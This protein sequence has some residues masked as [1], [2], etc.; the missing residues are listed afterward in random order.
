MSSLFKS[1]TVRFPNAMDVVQQKKRTVPRNF[2]AVFGIAVLIALAAWALSALSHQQSLSVVDKS[3]L[4]LD[5]AQRGT[6]VQSVSAQG[7]F[8]PERLRIVS[9]TQPGIVDQI[10]VKA[11]SAVSTGDVI[12]QMRNP[13]LEAAVVGAQSSLQVAQANLADARQ[14]AQAAIITEQSNLADA[15]AQLQSNTLQ[16]RSYASLHRLGMVASLPYQEAKI[17]AEK[18]ANA[19]R[20]GR[21]QVT[22]AVA[23]AQAKVAAA[24]AQVDQ[25]HAELSAAQAQVAALTVRAA[26]SGIVQAVD[27]DPGASITPTTQIAS[28]ADVHELKAVLQVAETDVHSVTIGMPAQIDTGNGVV[29]GRV[30]HIAPTAENGSVAVDVIFARPISGARPDANVNGTIV[31]STIRNAVSIARPAGASDGSA[32]DLFKIEKGGTRAVR[33]QVRLGRGSS[34]RVQVLSGISAGDT[35]IVSDMSNYASKNEL[36]LR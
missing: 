1:K 10:L 8:A 28:I 16:A 2:Y 35:V 13:Q 17:Q 30:S 32:I 21:E 20:N 34:T 12:A 7:S 6:L 33:L 9:A 29:E 14:Q 23:D 15:Q 18:S 11:G 27:V 5:V 3:S 31:I 22:V 19:V 36:Q 4:V 24:Q 25:A 26:V